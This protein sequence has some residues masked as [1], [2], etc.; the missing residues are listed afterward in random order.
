M[1]QAQEADGF[2]EEAGEIGGVVGVH[3]AK[4]FLDD[5][6][7]GISHFLLVDF[8]LQEAHGFKIFPPVVDGEEELAEFGL[9]EIDVVI[10]GENLACDLG[11]E[12]FLVFAV[13]DGRFGGVAQEA[14]VFPQEF[15][16]EGVESAH[17]DFLANGVFTSDAFTH[18]L[19]G[20][21]GERDAKDLG[22]RKAAQEELPDAG[23]DGG[24]FAGA[25]SGHDE[26]AGV[27]MFDDL[28]LLGIE[29]HRN[30][31]WTTGRDFGVNT[32]RG[33]DTRSEG[34]FA[35]E[36]DN[37]WLGGRIGRRWRSALF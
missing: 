29:S 12:V 15:T 18:F 6:E 20:L 23:G 35:R 17:F 2:A 32:G 13:E 10:I 31:P 25:G 14:A 22:G 19:G 1:G 30:H 27:E 7:F 37:Y 33:S 5:D 16:G 21:V 34:R 9:G 36:R 28:L 24:G 26:G 3:A 8:F 11:H 4:I